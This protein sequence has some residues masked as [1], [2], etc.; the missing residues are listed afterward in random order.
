MLN[1]ATTSSQNNVYLWCLT[2]A[3]VVTVN[4]HTNAFVSVQQMTSILGQLLQLLHAMF[5]TQMCQNL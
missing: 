3:A 5:M 2:S 4:M 1:P